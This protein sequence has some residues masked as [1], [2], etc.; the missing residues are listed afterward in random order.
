MRAGSSRSWATR[1]AE[2]AR[3]KPCCNTQICG[4]SRVLPRSGACSEVPHDMSSA[5]V[6]RIGCLGMIF[7]LG[8]MADTLHATPLFNLGAAKNFTILQAG[9]G[10]VTQQFDPSNTE[11]RIIGNV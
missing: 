8:A 10:T 1:R 6:K 2:L 5:G 4:I 9:A 3:I 7:I 11:G